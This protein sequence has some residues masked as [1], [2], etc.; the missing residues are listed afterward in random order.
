MNNIYFTIE[1]NHAGFT[2]Q[3]LQFSIIY[4]L[5]NSLEYK[6]THTKLKAYRSNPANNFTDNR[7]LRILKNLNSSKLKNSRDIYGHLGINDH[8]ENHYSHANDLVFDQI[9]NI[10]VKAEFSLDKDFNNIGDI[11]KHIEKEII[12]NS[13]SGN[14]LL[15]FN[16]LKARKEIL[17]L[18]NYIPPINNYLDFYDIYKNSANIKKR[19]SLFDST[20]KIKLLI[21]I[22]QGDTGLIQ[23][24]WN[25]YIPVYKKHPGFMKE[26]HSID[27]LNSYENFFY[28]SYQ[29]IEYFK[30]LENF[31]NYFNEEMFSILI[32]SDGYAR[33][34]DNFL[35]NLDK[36]NLN[37]KQKNQ[38]LAGLSE[39]EEK[40]FGIF[41][42]INNCRCIIGES[43]DQL[44]QLIDSVLE[45]D[46]TICSNQMQFIQKLINLFNSK[47]NPDL[48]QLYRGEKLVSPAEFNE[49]GWLKIKD[50]IN[51][52]NLINLK[53]NISLLN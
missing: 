28:D 15:K 16:Y 8:F 2:D 41:K 27:E 34:H 44:I 24:P 49:K 11:K 32:F 46:I 48:I 38:I 13:G 45:S 4:T 33:T 21:H 22:R 18:K 30:Y 3:L 19:N 14:I 51:A 20:K 37:K 52:P 10:D 5:G 47:N 50:S 42:E 35:K 12:K 6:Y 36:I 23:T 9:I 17:R 43:D 25:T 1:V 31:L 40:Q 26:H 7:L 29:P 39:Y 53:N